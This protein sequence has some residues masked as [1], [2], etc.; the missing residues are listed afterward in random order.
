MEYLEGIMIGGIAI[1]PLVVALV[2][3]AKKLGLPAEYAPY[4]NGG[5]AV[6]LWLVATQVVGLNPAVDEVV[7]VVAAAVVIFLSASG[8]HQ[9]GKTR[10]L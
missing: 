4:A 7:K 9:F 8:V 1:A 5:L 3:L 6:A 2:A 10:K